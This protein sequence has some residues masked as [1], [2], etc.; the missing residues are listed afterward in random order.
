MSR[1]LRTVL[2]LL[3][4][5]VLLGVP[6]LFA[7]RIYTERANQR[8]EAEEHFRVVQE[9]ISRSGTAAT[10]AVRQTLI[11]ND[12]LNYLV[13]VQTRGSVEYAWSRNRR[14]AIQLDESAILIPESPDESDIWVARLSDTVS[15]DSASRIIQAEYQLMYP[16]TVF[17]S[18]RD[19]L[20]TI[21]AFALLLIVVLIASLSSTTPAQAGDSHTPPVSPPTDTGHVRSSTTPLRPPDETVGT[22]SPENPVPPPAEPPTE[23][24]DTVSPPL[25]SSESGLSFATHLNRRLDLELQ[26]AA[27]NE[28]DVTVMYAAVVE[29]DTKKNPSSEVFGG[30]ILEFFPFEDL[31]YDLRHEEEGLCCIILP[32]VD[33]PAALRKAQRFVTLGR[34][35]NNRSYTTRLGASSRNGRLVESSRLLKEAREALKKTD[36]R[37]PVIGFLPDPDRYRRLVRGDGER[38]TIAG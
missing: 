4:I 13:V 37:A 3:S 20:L 1:I 10:D 36:D 21:I 6:T 16:D 26:R 27:E 28:L 14:H 32:G 34:R 29:S 2:V 8:S 25:V 9:T 24:A 35:H 12:R 38:F 30:L 15:V 18:I 22:D 33:L 23:S 17:Q 7:V 31:V 5:V 11:S 19:A